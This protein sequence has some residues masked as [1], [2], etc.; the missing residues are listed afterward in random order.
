MT[1]IWI[2]PQLS[3]R[4]IPARGLALTAMW[5]DRDRAWP[6]PIVL[7]A[8]AACRA[9]APVLLD[10]GRGDP[11]RKTRQ[12]DPIFWIARR[13]DVYPLTGRSARRR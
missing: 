3:G 7:R 9:P 1:P 2:E 5:A 6:L 11:H 8:R 10:S 13:T 12:G 4:I